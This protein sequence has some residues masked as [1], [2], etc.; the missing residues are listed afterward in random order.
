MSRNVTQNY[1]YFLDMVASRE[2]RVS[3][4]YLYC[5]VASNTIVASREGRVS[6]NLFENFLKPIAKS[7]PAR[8]V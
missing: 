3:R 8:D 7:R 5:M 2:G 4:N 6:R 1:Q